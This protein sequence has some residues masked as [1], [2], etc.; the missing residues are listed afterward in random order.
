MVGI[1]QGNLLASPVIIPPNREQQRIVTVLGSWDEAINQTTRL[2]DSK[3]RRYR[4]LLVRRL[5]DGSSLIDDGCSLTQR[6]VRNPS[7]WPMRVIGDFA[8]EVSVF[9]RERERE[10]LPV[11]SCTKHSGIV[12]SDE[13]FSGRQIYSADT[14][15]YK[16]VRFGQ[17]AYATNHLEE[18]SIGVQ[19]LVAAGLVSPMYTVFEHDD[20][21]VDSRFLITV[22]KTET[23]RQV[24]EI[25]TSSSVD[26]R[27]GLRWADFATL[28][29]ALPPLEEQRRLAKA[30]DAIEGDLLDLDASIVAL[31]TQKRGL[32][33]KLLTGEWRLD[34]RFDADALT[35]PALKVGGR[36]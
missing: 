36:S 17:F 34:G 20:Q 33:Q 3:R 18:G 28:P 30:I 32:M 25:N 31:R 5:F 4:G 26:R 21:L 12:L 1:S 27:G 15:G 7:G 24:F 29:F 22:L 8:S 16:V 9:N 35:P 6:R 11:L 23:Y 2:V 13:Y 19:S 10:S 14:A